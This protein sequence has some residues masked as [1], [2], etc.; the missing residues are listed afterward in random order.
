MIFHLD[1]MH[2]L[3]IGRI[4]GTKPKY[5]IKKFVRL[6]SGELLNYDEFG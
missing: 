6:V 3:A 1:E 5:E 4:Y 2:G